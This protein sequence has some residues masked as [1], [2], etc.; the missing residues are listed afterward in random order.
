[1]HNVKKNSYARHMQCSLVCTGM[2]TILSAAAP[3]F[4]RLSCL[5]KRD[6]EDTET[7]EIS[8]VSGSWFIH[9]VHVQEEI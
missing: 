9:Q 7:K 4:C 5:H 2:L 3:M 8:R 6:K 1:M